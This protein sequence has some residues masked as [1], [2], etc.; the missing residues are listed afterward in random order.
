MKHIKQSQAVPYKNSETCTAYEYALGDEAINGAVIQLAGRYPVDGL[1]QNEVS[2]ELVYVL[3]GEGNVVVEEVTTT[4]G[5]G[6]QVL[7]QPGEKYYFEG[8]M[9]L[10]IACTPAWTLE[11]HRVLEG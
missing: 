1:A 6:D 5:Q 11:Q 10:F 7:I 4:L 9:K 8:T 3:Q 2:K